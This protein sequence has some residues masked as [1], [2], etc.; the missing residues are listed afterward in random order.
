MIQNEHTQLIIF[1]FSLLES[2]VRRP[3]RQHSY[4]VIRIITWK[5]I[6]KTH[7]WNYM[8]GLCLGLLIKKSTQTTNW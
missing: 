1:F 8:D 2:G 7:Y 4:N 6:E 5:A 3:H